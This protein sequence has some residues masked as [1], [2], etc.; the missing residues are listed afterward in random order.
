MKKEEFCDVL[1]DINETYV[2]DA[3]S[4]Q[5]AKKPVWAKWGA[6]VACLALVLTVA[7]PQVRQQSSGQGNT[8]QPGGIPGTS[9]IHPGA[10][11]ETAVPAV[12][13]FVNEIDSMAS[14]D[15]DVQFTYYEKLPQTVWEAVLDDFYAFVGISY[16]EFTSKLPDTWDISNFY[17]ASTPGYKDGELDD[18]YRLHDYV[19]DCQT[20]RGGRL[21]IALCSFEE[22]LRD[23]FIDCD[24]PEYSVINGTSLVI[25]GY[26]DCYMAQ[27]SHENVNYDIE[28][29]NITLDELQ[30]LLFGIM[31]DL[32]SN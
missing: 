12:L 28:A 19:F 22:P 23:H 20:D 1:G 8:P 10:S 3:R 27:F 4:P 7:I 31:D 24:E 9:E 11:V 25:Y 30:D 2:R 17:S 29:S 14:M 15:M 16:D 18:E 5:R 26:G 21:T 13:L 6:M 32:A